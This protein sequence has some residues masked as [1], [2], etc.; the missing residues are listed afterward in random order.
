[1]NRGFTNIQIIVVKIELGE[2][3]KE[4]PVR[5]GMLVFQ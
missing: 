2:K 3:K 4:K 5:K 1:V